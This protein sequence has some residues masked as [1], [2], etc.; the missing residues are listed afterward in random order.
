MGNNGL[1]PRLQADRDR[2]KQGLHQTASLGCLLPR[3]EP[4]PRSSAAIVRPTKQSHRTG[5]RIIEAEFRGV[6][7]ACCNGTHQADQTTRGDQQHC[8]SG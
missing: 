2:L 4:G 3:C 1:E 8:G 6:P 7:S 5:M